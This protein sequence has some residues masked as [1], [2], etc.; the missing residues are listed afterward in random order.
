MISQPPK[1]KQA[2]SKIIFTGTANCIAK[3]LKRGTDTHIVIYVARY[4]KS[5]KHMCIQ[6]IL[7]LGG[8]GVCP[9]ENFE[10]F[11]LLKL[12]LRAFL[13]I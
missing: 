5:A 4:W 9:S 2:C 11:A 1:L 8:L 13:V 3:Y 12:N 6:S 7:N 10:N